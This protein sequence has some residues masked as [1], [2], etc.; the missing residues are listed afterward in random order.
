[1]KWVDLKDIETFVLKSGMQQDLLTDIQLEMTFQ[2]TNKTDEWIYKEFENQKN[3]SR[4]ILKTIDWT[5][6]LTKFMSFL[7]QVL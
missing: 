2:S 1:M 7:E 6:L 3:K 5:M 4:K